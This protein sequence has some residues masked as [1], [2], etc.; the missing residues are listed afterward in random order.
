MRS[1]KTDESGNV[2]LH[3]VRDCEI[4]SVAGLVLLLSV[5]YLEPTLPGEPLRTN[6]IE[7]LLTPT[8]ALSIAESLKAAAE[9]MLAPPTQ[10]HGLV[11]Q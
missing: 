10:V 2:F 7:F 1:F 9:A 11:I 8:L 4:D 3:P 5:L 6:Q